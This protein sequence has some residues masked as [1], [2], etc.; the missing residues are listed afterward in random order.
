MWP[1][2]AA[3]RAG[4][5]GAA[6]GAGGRREEATA[7]P[8]PAPGPGAPSAFSLRARKGLLCPPSVL[9]RGPSPAPALRRDLDLRPLPGP[10]LS[11]SAGPGR[12]LLVPTRPS[13]GLEAPPPVRHPRPGGHHR[14]SG[15]AA[16]GWLPAAGCVCSQE[17]AWAW[18]PCTLG[19]EAGLRRARSGSP[20]QAGRR[21]C[22]LRPSACPLFTR[23]F[24][25]WSPRCTRTRRTGAA[26]RTGTE[27]FSGLFP[28]GERV[29][30]GQGCASRG[31]PAE[32][33]ATPWAGE[34][35]GGC[36][37]LGGPRASS[38]ARDHEQRPAREPS[39]GVQSL[40]RA[41]R[42]GE[43]FLLLNLIISFK[44]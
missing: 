31:T 8:A 18:W 23:R 26:G 7:T 11:P 39:K 25:V 41:V 14:P 29:G 32:W 35:Q 10:S 9:D 16:L 2:G 19:G 13:L 6:A 33:P 24:V 34:E 27:A 4:S 12:P 3:P 21:L 44:V 28:T 37:K 1:G 36:A 15:P 43:V 20:A 5:R 17:G 30:G 22:G 40:F 38:S 42:V